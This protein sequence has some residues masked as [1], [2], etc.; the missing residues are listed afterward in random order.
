M[1]DKF[2][3]ELVEDRKAKLDALRQVLK[4]GEESGFVEY[5]LEGIIEELDKEIKPLTKD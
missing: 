2:N 1:E 4:E 3:I 5:S